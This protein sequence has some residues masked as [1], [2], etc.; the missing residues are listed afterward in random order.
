[1]ELV[2]FFVVLEEVLGDVFLAV[3]VFFVV[4]LVER[5]I[6]SSFKI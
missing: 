2:D 1:L 5:T 6:V 4:D 3:L